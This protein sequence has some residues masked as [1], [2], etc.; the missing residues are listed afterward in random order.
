MFDRDRIIECLLDDYAEYLNDIDD[1]ELQS[2]LDGG[3]FTVRA[4]TFDDFCGANGITD[5][6]SAY[7]GLKKIV[8]YVA[9]NS[10]SYYNQVWEEL[11][12]TDNGDE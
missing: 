5:Y 9:E 12:L 7:Q 2:V 10:P 1:D 6:K 11:F 8:D 3:V 4:V